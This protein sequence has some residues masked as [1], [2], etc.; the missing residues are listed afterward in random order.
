MK[1]DHFVKLSCPGVREIIE[2]I[3][4]LASSLLTIRSPVAEHGTCKR[5]LGV[6]ILYSVIANFEASAGKCG[7]LKIGRLPHLARHARKDILTS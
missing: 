4:E 5:H 3:E 1:A 6:L 7:H 2:S